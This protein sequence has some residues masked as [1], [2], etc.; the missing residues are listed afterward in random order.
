[1]RQ[2]FGDLTQN[3]AHL[4]DEQTS[5]GR[6]AVPIAL[7]KPMPPALPI[8]RSFVKAPVAPDQIPPP[9]IHEN[10]VAAIARDV[11]ERRQRPGEIAGQDL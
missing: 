1:M 11:S 5:P 10:S 2:E 7:I 6:Y 9:E 3:K 8:S 4:A